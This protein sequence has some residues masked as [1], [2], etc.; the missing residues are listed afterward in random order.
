MLPLSIRSP[1]LAIRSPQL[2]I[3]SAPHS[4][5]L[6][7]PIKQAETETYRQRLETE[8]DENT[9]R[10]AKKHVQKSSY[11]IRLKVLFLTAQPL[12]IRSSRHPK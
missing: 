12:P 6:P 7:L 8:I 4:A 9:V 5:P 2:S 3:F 10:V 11:T 1:P